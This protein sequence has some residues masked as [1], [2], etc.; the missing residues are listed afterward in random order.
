MKRFECA[1]SSIDCIWL[2]KSVGVP[3]L[4]DYRRRGVKRVVSF[5]IEGNSFETILGLLD[6]GT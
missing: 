6:I 5:F 4:S 3:A 2:A 1:H